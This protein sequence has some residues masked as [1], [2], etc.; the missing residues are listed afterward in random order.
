MQKDA[1]RVAPRAMR[2]FHSSAPREGIVSTIG[3]VGILGIMGAGIKPEPIVAALPKAE[4]QVLAW[5]GG[6]A[7]FGTMASMGGGKKEEA[8]PAA[9][10]EEVDW[11][12]IFAEADKK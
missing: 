3:T 1:Q 2:P 9:V 11:E 7:V 8:A 6:M 5:I 12:A 4:Y 10:E